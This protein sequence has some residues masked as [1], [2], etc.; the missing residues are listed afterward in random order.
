MRFLS[1]IALL[2]LST[3]GY[4]QSLSVSQLKVEGLRSPVGIDTNQPRF[5]WKLISDRENVV[6]TSYRLIVSS[7]FSK[8]KSG[9][10]DVWDSGKQESAQ[11]LWVDYEGSKLKSNSK[12]YWRVQA[13]AGSWKAESKVDSFSVALL[14]PK[15]WMGYWIG[16]ERS[17]KA[18][19]T[20]GVHTRLAARYLRK[21]FKARKGVVQA[22][23]YVAGLGNYQLYLNGDTL[24]WGT[25]MTPPTDYRK[26][27][28]YDAYDVTKNIRTGENLLGMILGNGRYFSP[29]TLGTPHNVN[30]GYPVCKVNLIITYKDGGKEIL[31]TDPTWR[32]S[33]NGPIVAN[34]LYDGEN[35][36]ARLEFGDWLSPDYDDSKWNQAE[37]V[38]APKGEL[39]ANMIAQKSVS[40]KPDTFRPVKI[41][42]K[43]NSYI[44]DFGE[45]ITGYVCLK[46]KG[47]T[48]FVEYAERLKKMGDIYRDNLREAMSRDVYINANKPKEVFWHPLFV[49]HG[50][51]YVKVSGVDK[52]SES[53]IYAI[54]NYTPME[55]IGTFECSNPILNK[56]YDAAVR[57]IRDNYTGIPVDCPQRDE[58]LPWLGDRAQVALGESYI[59]D[60]ERFYT[61][62][63]DDISDAQL[64]NGEL[65]VIAPAFYVNG[66][67]DISWSSAYISINDLLYRQFGNLRPIQKHYESMKKWLLKSSKMYT[68]FRDGL[69]IKNTYGDWCI[70]PEHLAMT[71]SNNPRRKA[72]P[73]LISTAY[74]VKCLSKLDEFA[75]LTKTFSD[76]IKYRPLM[77]SYAQALNRTFLKANAMAKPELGKPVYIDS[78]YYDNNSA[79]ST[80]L[81]LAFD[82]APKNTREKLVNNLKQ[83]IAVRSDNHISTGV[84]G[85]SWQMRTLSDNGLQDI[86][87]KLATNK[88]Y[89]SWGYMV[90]NGSTTIWELWNGD[91]AN[92]SMN[93][94]NHV[95]LLGDLLTWVYQYLGGIRSEDGYRHITLRPSFD[96]KDCKYV[97]CSYDSPYGKIV[98]N[99]KK[100]ENRVVWD[101]EIPVGASCLI[102]KGKDADTIGSGKYHF[103]FKIEK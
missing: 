66:T 2:C 47:K 9:K 22:M 38:L 100:V 82:I 83:T 58:R 85:S 48:I 96:I 102:Y 12:Y 68:N 70:P 80:I 89:P 103:E 8:C 15:E 101:V 94:G 36:D 74:M 25:A 57:T 40:G 84:I 63:M 87:W 98:S 21:D 49:D 26:R 5:S 1:F 54:A 28:L 71:V 43:G 42:K 45:N 78:L 50:F 30:F 77:R 7:S 3:L 56:V 91:K 97:N 32:L 33:V 99:W 6:Q 73:Y 31:S 23:L 18:D 61:K 76:T 59:F 13:K 86:A 24:K 67:R 4:A 79:T 88:T 52:F 29:R 44:V 39:Q 72:S 14:S 51:R 95:M 65:P 62:W 34:N 41:F 90:E 53:D 20:M 92:P 46:T 35:Y 16:W 37:I 27:I 93:S 17:D 10:G 11:Q 60:N 55:T 19:K 69:F 75:H 81:P 64:P